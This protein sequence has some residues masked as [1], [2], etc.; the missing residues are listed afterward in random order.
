MT[1]TKEFAITYLEFFK[2]SLIFEMGKKLFCKFTN[3]YN[4]HKGVF[5]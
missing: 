3:V 1:S 5:V 4:Q 2:K